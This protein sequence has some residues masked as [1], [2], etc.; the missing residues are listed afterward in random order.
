[1]QKAVFCNNNVKKGLICSVF[2]DR[3]VFI[4]T[5]P[6]PKIFYVKSDVLYLAPLELQSGMYIFNLSSQDGFSKSQKIYY[7]HY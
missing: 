5:N 6:F 3:F 2:K 1:M 4:L 7:E